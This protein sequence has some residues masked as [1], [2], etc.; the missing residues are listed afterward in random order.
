MPEEKQSFYREKGP[1]IFA[2]ISFL[3]FLLSIFAYG[4]LFLYRKNIQG[5]IDTLTDSFKRATGAFEPI[6][7]NELVQTS[8]KINLSKQFLAKHTT[9]TPVFDF[10]EQSTLKSIRFK[11]FKYSFSAMESPSILMGG[12]ARDYSSL[13]LQEK[14]WAKNKNIK[15]ISFSKLTLGEKGLVNFEVKL[16]LDPSLIAYGAK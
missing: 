13:A 8:E 6:L 1:G 10:L 7:I 4:G 3:I 5:K 9:L 12:L 11:N 16:S 15:E 14:I 2:T